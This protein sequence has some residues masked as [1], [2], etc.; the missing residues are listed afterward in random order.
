MMQ[1][2]L[3]KFRAALIL[4]VTITLAT[5]ALAQATVV[6]GTGNPDVDVPAVQAAVNLGGEVV[7]R[8]HFSFNTPPTIPTALQAVGFPPATILISKAVAV[9]GAEDA[10]I[11]RGTIPF[12]VAAPGASVSIQK[13]ALREPVE[14]CYCRLR[15]ERP[16]DRFV[17]HRRIRTSAKYP[18]FGNRNQR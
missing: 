10:I 11:E 5:S 9:S 4:T 1:Q 15:R 13:C 3:F 7:L 17:P 12:Y 16:G 14:I 6:I 18:V 2:L 8:G